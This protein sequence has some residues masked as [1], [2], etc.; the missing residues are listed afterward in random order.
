MEKKPFIFW[1]ASWYPTRLDP[2]P[3]DFIQRHAKALALYHPVH[4]LHIA[5]DEHGTITNDVFV[6][7]KISGQLTETIVYYHPPQVGVGIVDRFLSMRKFLQVGK[8]LITEIAN[9]NARG[10]L[11]VH[12]A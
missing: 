4:V 8:R 5:K 7:K 2:F 9:S 10:F 11:H 12:V 6:E 3:G 1:L